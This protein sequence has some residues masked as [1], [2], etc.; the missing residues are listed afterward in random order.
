MA[1]KIFKSFFYISSQ[2][3]WTT[4]LK[5]GTLHLAAPMN[6]VAGMPELLFL[7]YIKSLIYK[8]SIQILIYTSYNRMLYKNNNVSVYFFNNIH[9]KCRSSDN[10]NGGPCHKYSISF[11]VFLRYIDSFKYFILTCVPNICFVI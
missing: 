10:K 3:V 2:I 7:G 6:P 5:P 9:L 8:S 4:P 11:I 1:K